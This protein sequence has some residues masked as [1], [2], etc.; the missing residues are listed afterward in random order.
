[1]EIAAE[2]GPFVNCK[3]LVMVR[4]LPIFAAFSNYFFLLFTTL[5]VILG[6]LELEVPR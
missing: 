1:M 6:L 5:L 3:F 2:M 4:V